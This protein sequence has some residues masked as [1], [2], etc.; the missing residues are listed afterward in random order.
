MTTANSTTGAANSTRADRAR[1]L[2][3]ICN[4]EWRVFANRR[5]QLGAYHPATRLA[6]RNF[7]VFRGM[8]D[9]L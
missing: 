4:A 1:R 2:T 3:L 7:R 8:L 5:Q 9:R 6:F